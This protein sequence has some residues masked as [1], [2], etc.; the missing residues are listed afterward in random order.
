MG[1]FSNYDI[2]DVI[3]EGD[4]ATVYKCAHSAHKRTVAVKVLSQQL[5]NRH[6]E[7]TANFKRTFHIAAK[8]NHPNIV[9]IIERGIVG[10]LPYLV[11]QYVD[12][13]P[14]SDALKRR[15]LDFNQ[16]LDVAL[17]ISKA[18]AYAHKNGVIHRNLKP[19]NIL[20]SSKGKILIAD[21]GI[22]QLV[23]VSPG[24][25]QPVADYSEYISPEQKS[26]RGALTAATDVY[27]LGVLL[28]EMFTGQY[29]GN[30]LSLPSSHDS[31]IPAYLDEVITTCLNPDPKKRYASA[32]GVKDK[33]LESMWGAHIE[34]AAKERALHDM[35]DINTR[36]AL[37]DVVQENRFGGIYLCENSVNHNS[38]IVKKVVGTRDGYKEC[39]ILSNLQHPNVVNIYGTST[40]EGVFIILMEYLAGGSLNDRL[41]NP[42][43]WR[44]AVKVVKDVCQGMAFI[45]DNKLVHGNLRPSNILFTRQGTAKVA[46][47]ALNAHCLEE[48][49]K[50]NWYIYPGEPKNILAD[51]YSVGAILFEMVTGIVPVR[52]H[53]ELVVNDRYYSLPPDLQALLKRLLAIVPK[54]RYR[55]FRE[56]I[57]E[58]D[59]L[60]KPVQAKKQ[61]EKKKS[62][63]APK[64]LLFILM[65]TV[66]LA[67]AF[68]YPDA[69][70]EIFES[71][72]AAIGL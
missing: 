63:G 26:G 24:Q 9:Q 7:V 50:T 49:A 42:W 8:L 66:L 14:L 53:N 15:S 38:L 13:M 54:D 4:S 67:L 40:D 39:T 21:F 44:K 72:K 64:S 23:D 10:E 19:S 28:Y 33:L 48:P 36:L 5:M 6:P 12:G 45:H 62:S 34:Q 70:L 11:M 17:Q 29:P 65:V 43:E 69:T 35:G 56:T 18:L 20:I 1:L 37:L 16:K 47:C 30:P 60:G 41:V 51:V 61:K 31:A 25:P 57:R 59:G 32:E 68:T 22:A 2:E 46:D 52:K 27:A 58:L 3:A 55:D 71:I